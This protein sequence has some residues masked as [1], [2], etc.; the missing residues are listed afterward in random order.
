MIEELF[1]IKNGQRYKVD[2]KTPSG[3]TLDFKSNLFTDISKIEC[4]KSYTFSLPKTINNRNIFDNKED[5]RVVITSVGTKY[6]CDFLIDGVQIVKGGNIYISSITSEFSAV[7][8]WDIVKGLQSIADD[9]FNL[10][11]LDEEDDVVTGSVTPIYD[12]VNLTQREFETTYNSENSVARPKYYAGVSPSDDYLLEHTEP[13]LYPL[14]VVPVPYLLRRIENHFGVLFDFIKDSTFNGTWSENTDFI[15]R[16][17]IPCVN[18]ELSETEILGDKFTIKGVLGKP[19]IDSI[20]NNQ[21]W[22]TDFTGTKETDYHTFSEGGLEKPNNMFF[23]KNGGFKVTGYVDLLFKSDSSI[24]DEAIT[25]DFMQINADGDN[26]VLTSING[27]ITQEA[28]TIDD[29]QYVYVRFE[30]RPEHG[31]QIIEVDQKALLHSVYMRT[32]KKCYPYSKSN[33][34]YDNSYLTF[35][36]NP[37][38]LYEYGAKPHKR[39]IISNLPSVSILDFLKSLFYMAGGFPYLKTDGTIGIKKYEDLFSNA[40]AGRCYDWSKYVIDCYDYLPEEINYTIS[41]FAQKNYYLMGSDVVDE[42][43]QKEYENEQDKYADG[44][45][46]IDIANGLLSEEKEVIKLPWYAPFVSN[47]KFPNMPTGNTIKYWSID[48]SSV[49]TENLLND[50]GFNRFSYSEAKPCYGIVGNSGTMLTM[51]A[52]NGLKDI[53]SYK[54]L[55]SMMNAC[56]T[57]KVKLSVP[58]FPLK[59]LNYSKP[60]YLSQF[61]SFFAI[62]H[63]EYNNGICTA[64]LIKIQ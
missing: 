34:R 21:V 1:I 15:A 16:G 38:P 54:K 59:E 60:V 43:E 63:I 28:K 53:E 41:D 61:S 32:S 10:N 49:T 6:E 62:V 14:P 7:M 5:I 17:V 47:S 4:S 9:N 55:Q 3:I 42:E 25:L 33:P 45:L 18:G 8:T 2:L 37:K 44:K 35:Y 51:T 64:E 19:S 24:Y 20:E 39:D 22:L 30:L 31:G 40:K 11:E 56:C 26:E 48:P 27:I 13:A 12:G 29:T 57:V 58:I 36:P 23:F 50:F 52:W 46:E